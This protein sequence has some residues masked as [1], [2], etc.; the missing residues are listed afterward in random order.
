[1]AEVT[2][3]CDPTGK[4]ISR[5]VISL[6]ETGTNRPGITELRILSE[7]FRT[8]PA[9]FIY[10]TDD[11][12][13]HLLERR[14]FGF[15]RTSDPDF[16][17][18]LTYTFP[19]LTRYQ[20]MAMLEPMTGLAFGPHAQPLAELNDEAAEE[21]IKVADSMRERRVRQKAK[22]RAPDQ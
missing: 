4:G 9:H 8:N 22:E 5:A 18:L 21:F 12:F 7:A 15:Y 14:R 3:N 11:P 19:K 13:E 6:Y 20:K 2:K 10:G 16:L 1:M 17:A